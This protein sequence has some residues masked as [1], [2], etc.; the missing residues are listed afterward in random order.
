MQN[1]LDQELK[2]DEAR[3]FRMSQGRL[4]KSGILTFRPKVAS[5]VTRRK[6]EKEKPRKE[7]P[8]ITIKTISLTEGDT[9]VLL[10]THKKVLKVLRE[11]RKVDIDLSSKIVIIGLAQDVKEAELL[12]GKSLKE[13]PTELEE[14]GKKE[15]G[16]SKEFQMKKCSEA[17]SKVDTKFVVGRRGQV[18]RKIEHLSGARILK[19]KEGSFIQGSERAVLEAKSIIAKEEAFLLREQVGFLLRDGGMLIRKIENDLNAIIIIKGSHEDEVR[20]VNF[21]GS[22][23]ARASAKDMLEKACIIQTKVFLSSEVAFMARSKGKLIFKIQKEAVVGISVKG[24][25]GDKG[26]ATNIIG[27]QEAIDKAWS[28]IQNALSTK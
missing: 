15:A 17:L 7:D 21:L 20:A 9:S 28:M 19:S 5:V 2:L 23:M 8:M 24:K 4:D 1:Q 22:E 12:V 26:R 14:H 6:A 18:L 11:S 3:V 27:S 13:M 25:R 10:G 16:T